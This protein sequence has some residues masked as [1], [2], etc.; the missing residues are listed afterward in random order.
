MQ[1]HLFMQSLHILQLDL[2]SYEVDSPVV[3]GTTW[4]E[5]AA[6]GAA[7]GRYGGA[8]AAGRGVE[9]GES[10]TGCGGDGPV[11]RGLQTPL[12][13]A[14]VARPE[15]GES[16]SWPAP[17]DPC[18]HSSTHPMAE[19]LKGGVLCEQGIPLQTAGEYDL[20]G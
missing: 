10:G 9:S 3:H 19:D 4:D 14:C 20:T 1:Q 7:G 15:D 16:H 6:G 11:G 8:G 18:A 13:D 17:K 5:G 12:K 2:L